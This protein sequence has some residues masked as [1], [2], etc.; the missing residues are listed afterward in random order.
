MGGDPPAGEGPRVIPPPGGPADGR[1]GTL[2]PIE[3]DMGIS[4]IRGW[5]L[6]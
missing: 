4:T 1:H 6:Y 2:T 5:E 3:W